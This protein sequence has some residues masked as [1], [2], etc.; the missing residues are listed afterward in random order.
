MEADYVREANTDDELSDG[1]LDDQLP[2]VNPLVKFALARNHEGEVGVFTVL[3]RFL[4]ERIIGI[5]WLL[6]LFSA[7]TS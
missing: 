1:A 2:F 4:G 3:C 5:D 6:V 7:Q